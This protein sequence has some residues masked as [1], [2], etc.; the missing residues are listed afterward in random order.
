MLLNLPWQGFFRIWAK[1]GKTVVCNL[2]GGAGG[3]TCSSIYTTAFDNV[4]NKFTSSKGGGVK[5]IS[6][7]QTCVAGTN[8]GVLD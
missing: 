5:E 2:V 6:S 1:G 8:H 7:F 3:H 4:I